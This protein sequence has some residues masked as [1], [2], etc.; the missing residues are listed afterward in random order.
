[1]IPDL[2]ITEVRHLTVLETPPTYTV[3]C[4]R[5]WDVAGPNY[6]RCG[7]CGRRPERVWVD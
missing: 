3:F 1:M 5:V 6:G 4:C 2:N 7:L